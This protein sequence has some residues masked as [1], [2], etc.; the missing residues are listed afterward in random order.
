MPSQPIWLTLLLGAFF[1]SLPISPSLAQPRALSLQQIVASID[2][3]SPVLAE[4]RTN[5]SRARSAYTGSRAFPNPTVFG[6]QE[7][8]HDDAGTTERI[9]GVRQSLGFLWSQAAKRGSAKSAYESA[10][11]EFLEVRRELVVQ[12]LIL[13]FEYDRLQRQSN[14]MDSVLAQS[15][16]LSKATAARRELG[17]I[18]PYDEQRFA[19]EKIQLQNRKQELQQDVSRAQSELMRM[20]GLAAVSFQGLKL[21]DP[22]SPPFKSEDEAVRHALQYR[23][24]LTRSE[25]NVEAARKAV[26]QARRN[27]LPDVSL[28]I[29]DKTIDPGPGGLYVEGEIE[30]PLWGQRRSETNAARSELAQAEIQRRSQQQL[31]EQQ[32]RV[33]FRQLQLIEQILSTLESSPADSAN[34]NMNRGVRL[35]L[36]GEMGALE[37]VD[38]LRTGIDAQDAALRLRNSLAVARAELRR[39]AGLEPWE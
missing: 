33:A 28:G 18:A 10:Q 7:S 11:A 29:G 38:A 30:I 6:S 12:V 36:E 15:N 5:L 39:A 14:L 8:L 17:D 20:T 1:V 32:V 35:Y 22:P 19:L 23:A 26:S 27:Q 2:S 31:V 37:L 25:K 3:T 34:I 9:I 13:A 24:E 4:A 21:S 16:Q